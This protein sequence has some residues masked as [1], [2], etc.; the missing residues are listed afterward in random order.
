MK[1]PSSKLTRIRLEF[2]EYNFVVEYI[3]GKTNVAADALSRISIGELKNITKSVLPVYTRSKIKALIPP[4]DRLKQS[5]FD[6]TN[7]KIFIY[8]QF[9]HEFNRNIPRIKSRLIYVNDE[10][11]EAQITLFKIFKKLQTL[12]FEVVNKTLHLDEMVLRL[13]IAAGNFDIKVVEWPKNDLF[14]TL[15]S[16]QDLKKPW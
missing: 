3:K 2:S 5:I 14:F 16:I 1:D 10:A 9:C 13:E 7:N 8:D 4:D 15:Y 12:N 6:E 11:S